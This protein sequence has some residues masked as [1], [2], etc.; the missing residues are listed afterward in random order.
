MVWWSDHMSGWGYTLM[1]LSSVAFWGLLILGIVVLVR[2][3]RN[4]RDAGPAYEPRPT[5]EQLLAERYARGEIDDDE[6]HRRRT[7]LAA[8]VKETSRP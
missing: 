5:P 2:L 7:A 1:T 6:Y 4:P 8:P 3:T